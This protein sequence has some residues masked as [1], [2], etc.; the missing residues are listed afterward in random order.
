MESNVSYD[1]V[2]NYLKNYLHWDDDQI[3]ITSLDQSS[4]FGSKAQAFAASGRQD[5]IVKIG[6][7]SP[8][9][10]TYQ[11]LVDTLPN[12]L[13]K[14]LAVENHRFIIYEQV[15]GIRLLDLI[16]GK[17][18]DQR[19]VAIL[20][21]I[22]SD[23]TTLWSNR[24]P[25]KPPMRVSK[26]G[27]NLTAYLEKLTAMIPF[28]KRFTVNQSLMPSFGRMV[29]Q[30]YYSLNAKAMTM[31]RNFSTHG[32][33]WAGNIIVDEN[34]DYVL[35]DGRDGYDDWLDDFIKLSQWRKFFLIE[36]CSV[37]VCESPK[38]IAIDYHVQYHP[39]VEQLES[40]T[41]AIGSA[42]AQR[43]GDT[44]WQK[45]YYLRTCID[46]I[47]DAAREYW[48]PIY[49]PKTPQHQWLEVALAL[50]MFNQYLAC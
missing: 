36:D 33:P 38:R 4:E 34:G 40:I 50:E 49:P 39:I 11:R 2:R 47:R 19:L 9:Y 28:D 18:D 42:F 32:D 13:P 44:H 5:V 23:L 29:W 7:I 1:L 6:D 43:V 16:I 41:S 21:N 27:L 37:S 15:F 17:K 46:H 24:L 35:L 22:L 25:Y 45:R 14:I 31:E 48:W 3:F 12:R 8:E 30:L 26:V 20:K 10:R